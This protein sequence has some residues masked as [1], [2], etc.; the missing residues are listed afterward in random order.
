[1][2]KKK[3]IQMARG[4]VQSELVLKNAKIINVFTKTIE[5]NDIAIADGIIVGIG[6]YQGENEIDLEGQ[7]VS[8]G[9]IDGHVHIESSMLTP[10]NYA[11]AT[12]PRGTTSIVADCHEIANVFGNKGIDFMLESVNPEVQDVFMMIPSCVPS[13]KY[14][15]NGAI[16]KAKDIQIYTNHP[17]VYGLGEMMDYNGTIEG[18]KEVLSKIDTFSH[19]TIDGHAPG[20]SGKDLNAYVLA[21][22]QTDHECVDPKELIEKV[23]R[24]MYIHLR[25]GSQTKNLIDLL[26]GVSPAIYDRI[27]FCSDD[28]HPSDIVNV[29]HIDQNIRL[30]IQHG[31][32]PIV[33]ISMAT[34]NIA[35]CYN[36]KHY[37]AIAPGYF[38]DLVVF[39]NLKK[40]DALMV[41]KKGKLV[42]RNKQPMFESKKIDISK[43]KDSV[44]INLEKINLDLKLNSNLVYIMGLVKNNITTEKIKKTVILEKGMFLSKNN[45]DLLKLAVIE[46]H[47]KTGNIG[48]GIVKGYGLKNAALALTIAHDS[49]NLI[50][51]GDNDEDMYIAIEKIKNIGGGIVLVSKGEIIDYLTLEVAGIMSSNGVEHV[52]NRLT[53]LEKEI[54]KLGVSVDIEDPFLQLAF[55]S[56]P[57]VPEIKVTDKGLFDVKQFKLISLEVGEDD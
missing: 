25:E 46:R 38:A 18:D 42:S 55:L 13:T 49:H 32:D 28:L 39:K 56:L 47:Q 45:P 57:V 24:G 7:Y 23:K 26:P 51:L 12:V 31:L 16:L 20:L 50:C 53:S 22:V 35:N 4:E 30:A 41:Y 27:L 5:E 17:S 15:S 29:G 10:N 9:F 3:L 8:P 21:G 37:G 2:N 44:N 54:R 48:F 43:V 52:E 36:L 33:A 1:M 14:E 19:L 6:K 11:L 40:I 34:I